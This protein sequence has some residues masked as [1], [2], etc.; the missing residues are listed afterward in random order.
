MKG[1]VRN[2]GVVH[3]NIDSSKVFDRRF[4]N[5][6]GRF[7]LADIAI[8]QHEAGSSSL[9]KVG[10]RSSGIKRGSDDVIT[11]LQEGFDQTRTNAPRC[12]SDDCSFLAWHICS[13]NLAFGLRGAVGKL[14][15][16]EG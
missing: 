11:L 12:S 8:H 13:F 9:R 4:D 15:V 16:G 2:S 14:T 10:Q 6:C 7:L 1:L 5:F 3:E